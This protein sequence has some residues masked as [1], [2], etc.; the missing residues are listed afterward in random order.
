MS[1]VK[2]LAQIRDANWNTSEERIKKHVK[3]YTDA[4]NSRNNVRNFVMKKGDKVQIKLKSKGKD[5]GAKMK[6]DWKPLNG[7][8]IIHHVDHTKKI[9][10]LSHS[11]SKK[12][13]RKSHPFDH[14][15]KFK[16]Q[17]K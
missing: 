9:C 10:T 4:Y 11:K 17:R 2:K 5:K 12:V 13:L 3:R 6:S 7:F 15:R 14:I 1:M 16:I 8:Y